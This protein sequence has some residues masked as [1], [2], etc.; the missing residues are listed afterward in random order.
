MLPKCGVELY[1]QG[2]DQS[3]SCILGILTMKAL[4]D[5]LAGKALHIQEKN[6]KEQSHSSLLLP[7]SRSWCRKQS[8]PAHCIC[9]VLHTPGK[10]KL[11]RHSTHLPPIR[12]KH[13]P[14]LL[15]LKCHSLSSSPRLWVAQKTQHSLQSLRSHLLCTNLQNSASHC[16][17]TPT[18]IPLRFSS[19]T[20][21]PPLVR[22]MNIRP[23]CTLQA[24]FLQAHFLQ[25]HFYSM[26]ATAAVSFA[27]RDSIS[28]AS[29][30]I[31]DLSKT[32]ATDIS[33]VHIGNCLELSPFT[34]KSGIPSDAMAAH[35]RTT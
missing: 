27:Q 21:L 13:K 10:I 4:I 29:V 24:H 26:G 12:M 7:P 2:Q 32:V 28:I 18:T 8:L 3:P 20:E 25:A 31:P 16:L 6:A 9:R 35:A 14:C 5:V 11:Q 33:G 17:A 19:H 15:F 34:A 23:V 22:V 30:T 1:R